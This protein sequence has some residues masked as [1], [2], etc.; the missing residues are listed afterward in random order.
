MRLNLDF[1]GI[2]KD[3]HMTPGLELNHGEI[4]GERPLLNHS[5]HTMRA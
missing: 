3:V 1:E 5:Y 4:E 2:G